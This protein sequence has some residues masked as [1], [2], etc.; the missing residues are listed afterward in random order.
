MPTNLSAPVPR[1]PCF[2]IRVDS[3][4]PMGRWIGNYCA[5]YPTDHL[6]DAAQAFNRFTQGRR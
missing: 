4:T 3:Q 6:V 1:I 5:A 2:A